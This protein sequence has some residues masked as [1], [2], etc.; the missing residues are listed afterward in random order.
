M[1][2]VAEAE[3]VKLYCPEKGRYAFFNSPF[4]PHKL[5][6]SVDLYPR[7]EFGGDAYSPV[8]GEV[9]LIRKV[10]APQGHGFTAAD[11]ETVIVIRNK[12]NPDTVTKLLHADP[13]VEVG[14][15]VRVGDAIGYTLRS[16]YYGWGTSPHFHAEVRAPGDPIRARGGYRVRRLDVS[17]G[18]PVDEIA[19]EVIETRPEYTFLKIQGSSS[20]LVG[21]VNGEPAIF[22]GGIPYYRWMGAHLPDPPSCGEFKLFGKTIGTVTEAFDR[23][24]KADCTDFSFEVNGKAILGLSLTLQPKSEAIVKVMP[25]RR[26]SLSPSLGDWLEVKLNA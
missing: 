11:H 15:S 3:G 1:V 16:G 6:S 13:L 21:H 25:L 8:D 23:A 4:P 24:C 14:D 5:N 20:G 2:P 22:D 17:V 9:E 7:G 12:E 10:K 18:T 26:N 19:G